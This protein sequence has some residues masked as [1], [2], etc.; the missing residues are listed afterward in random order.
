[1]RALD[2]SAHNH[3]LYSTS[4]A[5]TVRQWDVDAGKIIAEYHTTMV[6]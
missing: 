6:R 4:D 2:Y 1:M 5:G 3:S